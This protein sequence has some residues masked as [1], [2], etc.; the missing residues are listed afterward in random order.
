M[1]IIPTL[2]GWRIF[3]RWNYRSILLNTTETLPQ[4]EAATDNGP[5][6]QHRLAC[7]HTGCD[8]WSRVGTNARAAG[9]VTTTDDTEVV[10]CHDQDEGGT[11]TARRRHVRTS[12]TR[13]LTE[14]V[15]QY[16]GAGLHCNSARCGRA[17]ESA[18]RYRCH[19]YGPRSTEQAQHAIIVCLCR[20]SS[21]SWMASSFR[22][23]NRQSWQSLTCTQR[24]A[25][26]RRRRPPFVLFC[27]KPDGRR[28]QPMQRQLRSWGIYR[29]D[30]QSH[31]ASGKRRQQLTL[32]SRNCWAANRQCRPAAALRLGLHGG[33]RCLVRVHRQSR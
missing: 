19:R 31:H 29:A 3:C 17:Q 25:C 8:R 14:S 10:Q 24:A 4:S 13:S 15:R 22:A 9:S 28:V 21:C 12:R 33:K 18:C 2:E 26:R 32:S 6:Q 1:R 23:C 30:T 7:T 27:C 16:I 20:P 11:L 5:S